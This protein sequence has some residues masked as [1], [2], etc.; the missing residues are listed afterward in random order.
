[1]DE[2][3]PPSLEDLDARL[4]AVQERV[5]SRAN[6]G[7]KDNGQPMS[8]LGLAFRVGIELVSALAVGVGI[9]WLLDR[10]LGTKPW[11]M[12]VFFFLGSAAGVLNVWRAMSGIGP[13]PG[14]RPVVEKD[15]E[16]D[17]H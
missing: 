13:G 10:W 2:R 15:D 11:L 7:K 1:M 16:T 17:G 6:G 3:K 9:G 12:V 4:R 14:Y 5:D 8:G